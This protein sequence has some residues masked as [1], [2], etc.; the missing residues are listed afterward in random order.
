MNGKLSLLASLEDF[1]M[2]SFHIVPSGKKS[3]ERNSITVECVISA[4]RLPSIHISIS[5]ENSASCID[6][7]PLS[8]CEHEASFL[9]SSLL[10][11]LPCN[12]SH[13]NI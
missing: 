12:L 7:R 1:F 4:M 11:Q 8:T 6:F 2:F 10:F 5:K 3:D 13:T 9:C